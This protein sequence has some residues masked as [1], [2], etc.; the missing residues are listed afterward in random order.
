MPGRFAAGVFQEWCPQV[1]DAIGITSI[2][3]AELP[4]NVV[5]AGTSILDGKSSN[6]QNAELKYEITSPV[7]GNFCS[8]T[9]YNI[10]FRAEHEDDTINETFVDFFYT[11]NSDNY[12]GPIFIPIN[13]QISYPSNAT[14]KLPGSSLNT[15]GSYGPWIL[16]YTNQR[17]YG[18]LSKGHFTV[19]LEFNGSAITIKCTANWSSLAYSYT[20]RSYLLSCVWFIY[21]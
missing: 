3:S 16:P 9:F 18:G 11:A 2:N 5:M 10:H 15:I 7:S 4:S 6:A 1:M 12:I 21:K 17:L 13:T 14:V 19:S 8:I 20:L